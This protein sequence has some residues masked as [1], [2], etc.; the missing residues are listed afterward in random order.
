MKLLNQLYFNR[1]YTTARTYLPKQKT[2]QGILKLT[3]K[4]ATYL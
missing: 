1:G 2:S 4:F 3:I